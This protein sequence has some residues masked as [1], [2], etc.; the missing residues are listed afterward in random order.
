MLGMCEALGAM[1]WMVRGD[2]ARGGTDF[3]VTLHSEDLDAF[4]NG[5]AGVVDAVQ[6]GLSSV[7]VSPTNSIPPRSSSASRNPAGPSIVPSVGGRTF[8]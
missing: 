5:G 7:R 3:G 1:R 4:D 2:G 8:N 6:H